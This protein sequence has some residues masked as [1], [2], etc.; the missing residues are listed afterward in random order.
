VQATSTGAKFEHSAFRVILAR[1][2]TAPEAGAAVDA[3]L[4]IE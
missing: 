3:L 4:A 2:G 1:L